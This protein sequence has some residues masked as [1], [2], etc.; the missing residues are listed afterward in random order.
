V[1]KPEKMRNTHVFRFTSFTSLKWHPKI[2]IPHVSR[3]IIVVRMAV[4]RSESTSLT[5]A[6]AKTAVS[7]AKKA[8]RK[9]YNFHINICFLTG[10]D[11]TL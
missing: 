1:D 6:L 11:R 3:R 8:D 5:P 9:A 7:A 2:T 4:A 10:R